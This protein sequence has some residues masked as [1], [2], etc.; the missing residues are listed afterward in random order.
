MREK[1]RPSN[2][3][4]LF[5]IPSGLVLRERNLVF[6]VLFVP[7][8]DEFVAGLADVLL[9]FYVIPCGTECPLF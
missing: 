4:A 2:G 6:G 1:S 9:V 5:A 7:Q 8:G 3:S